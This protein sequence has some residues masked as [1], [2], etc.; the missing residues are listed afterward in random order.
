MELTDIFERLWKDYTDQN[1]SALKVY[2]LF[3]SKGETVVNDHIAFR[4]FDD[5]RIDINILAKPFI[6]R[7]YRMAGK[8]NFD[9]KHLFARHYELPGDDKAPRIFISQLITKEFSGTVQQMVKRSVDGIESSVLNSEELIFSGNV[10]GEPEYAL[11]EKLREESEYAAWMYVFGFRAN[12]FTVSVNYLKKYNTLEKVNKLV[13]ENG[14][15]LNTSGGEIKGTSEQLLR[16]SSTLAD[17]VDINFKEGI[18]KIP[19]CYYEFAQRYADNNG[20]LYSGFIAQSA[21]KIF[22]ST[23]YRK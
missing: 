8:Y 6:E 4:T 7:G 12:H 3:T 23:N 13:K 5:P 14:F 22:E 18:R 15:P 17:I 2:N 9:K 19:A 21:D 20:K 16:Q 11:Y 1:P 10:F